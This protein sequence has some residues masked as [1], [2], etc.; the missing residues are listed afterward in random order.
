MAREGQPSGR[1]MQQADPRRMLV[2]T[3]AGH[4]VGVPLANVRETMRPLPIEPLRDAPPFALGLAVIR[5]VS[6]PV[7]DLGALLGRV[8]PALGFSRF[9]TLAV[10]ERLV[11][12]AVDRVETVATVDGSELA[13]MPP[14]LAQAAGGVV[15]AVG[16]HDAALLLV[17]QA[18]RIL[19]D[20]SVLQG[21]V[22]P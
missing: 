20:G 8:G 6:V 21:E 1:T 15:E 18:S 9:V 2:V 17:L 3:G 7:V 19:P 13:A 11:A 12:L 10:G 14:L 4:R 5:G 16:L 22:T